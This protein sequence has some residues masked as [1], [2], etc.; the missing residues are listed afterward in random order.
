MTVVE[1]L[2]ENRTVEVVF[3]DKSKKQSW[4]ITFTHL[5]ELACFLAPM[6]GEL[7]V[8]LVPPF[9]C[10]KTLFVEEE[11]IWAKAKCEYA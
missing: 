8:D 2:K 3:C 1:A 9:H 6:V 5:T 10:H 4:G 7:E 11:D